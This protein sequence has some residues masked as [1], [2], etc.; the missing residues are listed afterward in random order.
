MNARTHRTFAAAVFSALALVARTH[1][2]P[3]AS[4][5]ACTIRGTA[6]ADTLVGGPGNDVI[7]GFGGD[8]T[9]IGAGGN[10]VI[11]GG[12]GNDWIEPD[13]GRDRVYGGDGNDSVFAFDGQAD[14]VDGGRGVDTVHGDGLDRTVRVEH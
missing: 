9:I 5:P 11:Y 12:P 14:F 13:L 3:V 7:C 1:A 4:Q 10:D 8:D 6:H 2:A